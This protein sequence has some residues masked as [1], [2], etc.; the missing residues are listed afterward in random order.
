MRA[1]R[2]DIPPLEFQCDSSLV[3]RFEFSEVRLTCAATTS[4]GDPEFESN[5]A[6]RDSLKVSLRKRRACSRQ[7]FSN[8]PLC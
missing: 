4:A 1:R 3:F 2:R 6:Q 7:G 8:E 5:Q